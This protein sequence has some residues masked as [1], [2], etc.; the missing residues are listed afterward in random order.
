MS[1]LRYSEIRK[2][3]TRPLDFQEQ[4]GNYAQNL[5]G[6]EIQQDEWRGLS[7]KG[8]NFKS[9]KF[10]STTW[11]SDTFENVTFE[12]CV[13]HRAA[14]SNCVFRN[15]TFRRVA[16][17]GGDWADSRFEKGV[18]ENVAL[19]ASPISNTG[20][21]IHG[22]EFSGFQFTELNPVERSGSWK[23]CGFKNS[24]FAKSDLSKVD[25]QNPQFIDVKF[26][27]VV[28][29]GFDGRVYEG[30]CERCVFDNVL[31]KNGDFGGDMIDV[32][33]EGGNGISV[34][35]KVTRGRFQSSEG[36]FLLGQAQDVEIL[37]GKTSLSLGASANVKIKEINKGS[38]S[39]QGG[40]RNI[41]AIGI[42]VGV[43]DIMHG[44]YEN[45]LFKNV[46]TIHLDL[47]GAIFKKCK[48]EN[49][50]VRERL[51][52]NP[53]PVFEDCEFVNFHRDSVGVAYKFSRDP[54]IAYWLPFEQK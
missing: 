3:L 4:F 10:E 52:I 23:Q 12:D 24:S 48:F 51:Y 32:K 39:I 15:C 11:K 1:E 53:P 34:G 13:F 7:F 9:V 30:L 27:E 28:W 6:F 44:T 33:L 22:L 46:N 35:G 40:G 5:H 20:V 41:E 42:Q 50:H 25:F 18:W 47:S 17:L 14:L 21:K 36:A 29:E 45:C 2:I 49:F 31:Q 38:A 8:W 16:I 37:G 54:A 43:L 26:S 19:M